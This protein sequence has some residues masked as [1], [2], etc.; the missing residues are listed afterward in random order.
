MVIVQVTQ[1]LYAQGGDDSASFKR[2]NQKL[3]ANEANQALSLAESIKKEQEDLQNSIEESAPFASEFLMKLACGNSGSA[4]VSHLDMNT[5][6][7]KITP[8][9]TG[10]RGHLMGCLKID[11]I[12]DWQLID[13]N[14]L[15]FTVVFRSLM[16]GETNKYIYITSK[17]KNGQWLFGV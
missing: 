4:I 10:M 9:M 2:F 11:R 7:S 16:S 15:K 13:S 12:Y 14:V 3:N 17:Q 1:S 5:P 8:P 6:S